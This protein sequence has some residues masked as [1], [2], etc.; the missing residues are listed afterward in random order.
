MWRNSSPNETGLKHH[1]C[2]DTSGISQNGR[3]RSVSDVRTGSQNR[4]HQ[5]RQSVAAAG[6]HEWQ[7]YRREEIG[8]P[9]F[10]YSR[11][12]RRWFASAAFDKWSGVEV[13]WRPTGR[14]CC[15]ALFAP[16]P[17]PDRDAPVLKEQRKL[18]MLLPSPLLL[19]RRVQMLPSAPLVRLGS[20]HVGSRLRGQAICFGQ[21]GPA[22][23]AEFADP[24][25][26]LRLFSVAF[27]SY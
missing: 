1:S 4:G 11:L 24:L 8:S 17:L 23:M 14:P 5:S 25:C 20:R 9:R 2:A 26:S 22:D 13:E 16:R 10:V 12:G 7:I 15:L 18:I 3:R 21:E 27:E 19:R 6:W